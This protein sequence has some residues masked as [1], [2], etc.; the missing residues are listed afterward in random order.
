M[1]LSLAYKLLKLFFWIDIAIMIVIILY[2]QSPLPPPPSSS[3]SSSSVSPPTTTDIEQKTKDHKL[4]TMDELMSIAHI[5]ENND[6]KAQA[7]ITSISKEKMNENEKY[8]DNPYA[9]VCLNRNNRYRYRYYTKER[10]KRYFDTF[11]ENVSYHKNIVTKQLDDEYIKKHSHYKNCVSF[12]KRAMFHHRESLET[13]EKI[14]DQWINDI[15]DKDNYVVRDIHD[16]ITQKS[17]E[18]KNIKNTVNSME[19]KKIMFKH[20]GKLFWKLIVMLSKSPYTSRL[21]PIRTYV[22]NADT[23]WLEYDQSSFLLNIHEYIMSMKLNNVNAPLYLTIRNKI[24][25]RLNLNSKQKHL[26]DDIH[27]CVLNHIQHDLVNQLNAKSSSNNGAMING[28]E[29]MDFE[30]HYEHTS[31]MTKYPTFWQEIIW[32]NKNEKKNQHM[33]LFLNLDM[34]NMMEKIL[35]T[36]NNEFEEHN[37]KELSNGESA[38]MVFHGMSYYVSFVVSHHILNE[39]FIGTPIVKYISTSMKASFK[40]IVDN[41]KNNNNN[42]SND[43][44]IKNLRKINSMIE[45]SCRAQFYKLFPLETCRW[46]KKKLSPRIQLFKSISMGLR[47]SYVHFISNSTVLK[48]ETR[49]FMHPHN[50]Q[51][52]NE[53]LKLF[54]EK[55]RFHFMKCALVQEIIEETQ[56]KKRKINQRVSNRQFNNYIKDILWLYRFR[57]NYHNVDLKKKSNINHVHKNGKIQS[58]AIMKRNRKDENDDTLIILHIM[59]MS[60][61]NRY[62]DDLISTYIGWNAWFDG[63]L[64]TVIFPPGLLVSP[65]NYEIPNES[66]L[67]NHDIKNVLNP[68]KFKKDLMNKINKI[69]ITMKETHKLMLDISR[70]IE[71]QVIV[72]KIQNHFEL[73]ENTQQDDERVIDD[74]IKHFGKLKYDV[75]H[76]GTSGV[77][78]SHEMFHLLSH[79]IK[80]TI[81]KYNSKFIHMSDIQRRF[82]I[83]NSIF[84]CI[85]QNQ[86]GSDWN[87]LFYKYLHKSFVNN[88]DEHIDGNEIHKRA[89]SWM[90]ENY[91]DH[92]GTYLSFKTFVTDISRRKE[93]MMSYLKSHRER[94]V[95]EVKWIKDVFVEQMNQNSLMDNI[96]Y[97]LSMRKINEN[98]KWID[99]QMNEMLAQEISKQTDKVI[100]WL[101]RAFV[102]SFQNLW[103]PSVNS[104]SNNANKY[105]VMKSNKNSGPLRWVDLLRLVKNDKRSGSRAALG[106]QRRRNYDPHPISEYRCNQ[107]SMHIL[108]INRIFSCPVVITT[109]TKHSS[110]SSSPEWQTKTSAQCLK[111]EN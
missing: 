98:T 31:I 76:Y 99:E 23:T 70:N 43:L 10:E 6:M 78:I 111:S 89:L 83:Y 41:N 73:H 19:T 62:L 94:M 92:F 74:S 39:L 35:D 16:Y 22:E 11:N 95:R 102:Y 40:T 105:N 4:E 13:F 32:N 12:I 104:L 80:N 25:G 90:D 67:L 101:H 85:F 7:A 49:K 68:S 2:Y 69:Q 47:K 30:K 75:Y 61:Y 72:Q 103:C 77:V 21:L 106:F 59:E 97:N 52:N 84:D 44:N 28:G 5:I 42:N 58:T 82:Y 87:N 57:M 9:Y 110:M 37:H 66:F 79:I 34:M 15:F 18:I 48:S 64:E 60:R 8:C 27:Q 46:I 26:S 53:F 93:I 1:R 45:N 107:P 50:N 38:M 91:A 24:W 88:N 108:N 81:A 96:K 109:Q 36:L 54:N 65:V 29:E 71:N 20:I 55:K 51:D 86:V 56:E 3:S 33:K 63:Q 14:S 17:E 100:I